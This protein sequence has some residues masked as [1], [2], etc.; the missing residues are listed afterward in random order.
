M[1]IVTPDQRIPDIG[2][3]YPLC[4]YEIG[5]WSC[6]DIVRDTEPRES[7]TAIAKRNFHI[8]SDVVDRRYTDAICEANAELLS[9]QFFAN[10]DEEDRSDWGYDYCNFTVPGNLLVIP[11]PP[12]NLN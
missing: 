5:E 8:E 6:V 11:T 9:A 1:P 2:G 4:H 7:L 12:D 10:V 3:T